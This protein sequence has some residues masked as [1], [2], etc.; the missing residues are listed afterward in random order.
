MRVN[1]LYVYKLNYSFRYR[2]HLAAVIEKKKLYSSNFISLKQTEQTSE[3]KM[4][5]QQSVCL[6]YSTLFLHFT[7]ALVVES[8]P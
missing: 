1:R 4:Q 7:L 5:A 3:K 2:L 8:D 6:P